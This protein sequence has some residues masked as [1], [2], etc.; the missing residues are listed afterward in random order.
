MA[1][2]RYNYKA[3]QHWHR[4]KLK[5]K[6]DF[7]SHKLNEFPDFFAFSISPFA[8]NEA[9]LLCRGTMCHPLKR[10]SPASRSWPG[11]RVSKSQPQEAPESQNC[12]PAPPPG[13]ILSVLFRTFSGGRARS[14][15]GEGG[16]FTFNTR[17]LGCEFYIWSRCRNGK[18]GGGRNGRWHRGQ[19]FKLYRK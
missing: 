7:V 5:L 19:T 10:K 3:T 17:S 16:G 14:R 8:F 2:T 18:P 15:E 11:G 6:K 12:R 4:T 1:S 9:F 13:S